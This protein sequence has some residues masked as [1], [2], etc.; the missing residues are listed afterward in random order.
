VKCPREGCGGEIVE[1]GTKTKRTFY[2]CSNYPKCDF[3]SWDKPVGT[4]CPACGNTYMLQ[5]FSKAKGE[6]LKCPKCKHELVNQPNET[7][8]VNS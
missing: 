3:A 2:G 7:E 5:K 8:S 6:Y 4:A 1:K